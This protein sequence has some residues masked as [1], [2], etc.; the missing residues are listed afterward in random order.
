MRLTFA[1]DICVIIR[2]CV[3]RVETVF[4]KEVAVSTLPIPEATN[5]ELKRARAE[6]TT[7]TDEIMLR[8]FARQKLMGEIA[9]A[10]IGTEDA[11]LPIF[12]PEREQ[13]LRAQYRAQASTRAC[14]R[15]ASLVVRVQFKIHSNFVQYT[16]PKFGIR[17]NGQS[18]VA[19][20]ARH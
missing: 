20:K 5:P 2:Y 17:R 3:E 8:F 7:V 19:P 1:I 16:P 15:R 13:F 10:K 6:V 11:A 12:L 18:G 4:E 9:N 14:P